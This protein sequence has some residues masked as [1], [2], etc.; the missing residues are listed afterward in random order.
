MTSTKSFKQDW[1]KIFLCGK[2][3]K[4]NVNVICMLSIMQVNV[5]RFILSNNKQQW[6]SNLWI[7]I[8]FAVV[9]K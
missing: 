3:L 7:N 6:D 5:K 4:Q 8:L 2:G 9:N 1:S